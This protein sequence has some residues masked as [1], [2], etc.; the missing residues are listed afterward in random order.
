MGFIYDY[1]RLHVMELGRAGN[2]PNSFQY[3]FVVNALL[4]A[5]VAGPLLGGIGTMVISKRLA[6]FSQAVGQA[7]L[8]G[9]ALGV[10]LGEP[11]T[12]P[13]ASLF[14][15]CILFALTMNYTRNRTRMKQDTVIGVFLSIS[16]AV[17]ACVLLYVTAKVNMHVLDNILFGSILTVNDT[18]MNVLLLIGVLCTVVGIPTY[19]HMLLASLNPSLAQVRGINAKFYDYVFVLMITVVTVACLKIVGAVLVEALL[20]IPAASARNVS[21]SVRGFFFYS[22]IFATVSC[23]LGIIVP[24]QFEIPVP[25]GGAIIL[26]AS[27]IFVITAGLRTFSGS[28]REAAA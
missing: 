27:G 19:N 4:C 12:A 21:R 23:L 26:V 22:V 7:A 18:D 15:F 17:G 5:V 28:F 9:V 13:Y 24:M 16:L 1:V 3:A 2:L 6:F 14:G 11:V 10:M 20:I 8:T 25:S